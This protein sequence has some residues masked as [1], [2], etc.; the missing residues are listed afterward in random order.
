MLKVLFALSRLSRWSVARSP[1]IC[2]EKS[3][4]LWWPRRLVKRRLVSFPSGRGQWSPGTDRFG[5]P[6]KRPG[7]RRRTGARFSFVVT[8]I[9]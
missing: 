4:R 6:P 5:M 3:R 8:A 9:P 1:L 7:S 2:L